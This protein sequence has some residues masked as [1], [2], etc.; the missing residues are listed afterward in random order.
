MVDLPPPGKG[1]STDRYQELIHRRDAEKVSTGSGGAGP[2]SLTDN[3]GGTANDT[4]AVITDTN[5][6][7]SADLT[8]VQDAIADLA[9]KINEILTAL[10]NA[11]LTN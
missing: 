9:A 4:I 6:A 11:N 10:D 5:N 1:V 3:S 2:T 8:P 7:G